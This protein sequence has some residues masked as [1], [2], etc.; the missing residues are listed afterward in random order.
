M[1]IPFLPTETARLQK[2]WMSPDAELYE[3]DGF[4]HEQWARLAIGWD[5]SGPMPQEGGLNAKQNL[6]DLG[7]VRVAVQ[8][9]ECFSAE[10][11]QNAN[12]TKNQLAR[13]LLLAKETN[14]KLL[15]R[16]RNDRMESIWCREEDFCGYT[17]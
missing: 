16:E 8:G 2:Y 6:F 11:Q 15:V 13:L 5:V 7:W 1:S 9:T 4:I 3:L 17:G 14:A 10:L 12:L